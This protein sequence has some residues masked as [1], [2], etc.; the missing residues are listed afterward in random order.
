MSN[1]ACPRSSRSA[2]PR[3]TRPEA[4]VAA[5]YFTLGGHLDLYWLGA[6]I[7]SLPADTR[8][9]ALARG[10]LR[11]DL[12]NQARALAADAV[13]LSPE[14]TAPDVLVAA[15]EAGHQLHIERY[16]HL[17]ADVKSASS[18][19]MPMLSVLLRELRGM[20]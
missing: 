1:A 12:S 10:A 4:T 18:I 7:S 6:Q 11:I 3:S 19:E 13:K 15:W 9:Q 5:V 14:V 16:R 20:A 17:L 2:S 8:W